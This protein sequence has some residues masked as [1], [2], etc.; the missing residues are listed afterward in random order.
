MKRL[1]E[2][3]NVKRIF[4]T[5]LIISVCIVVIYTFLNWLIIIKL[6]LLSPRETYVDFSIPL[7]VSFIPNFIWLRPPIKRLY[8]ESMRNKSN[9]G[10]AFYLVLANFA[11]AAPLISAQFW[12]KSTTGSLSQLDNIKQIQNKNAVKYYTLKT[13]YIDKNQY[14][15]HSTAELSGK[16]DK[17]FVIRSFFSL[18]ILESK[19]D[20]LN[21]TCFAW[22][23]VQ[24]VK[25][26]ENRLE[27]SE[28]DK[29][30]QEF[31]N[32][33]LNEI[34]QTDFSQLVYL[35]RIGNTYSDQFKESTKNCLKYNSPH[36][37]FFEAVNE[38]FEK[39]SG[40]K[41]A[42]IFGTFGIGAVLW[43]LIIFFSVERSPIVRQ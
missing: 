32:E 12:L 40:N 13:F 14:G 29:L 22:I 27:Q 16:R 37:N 6:Q 31:V 3:E 7:F 35:E 18:P 26:I 23:G 15:I 10:V 1:F 30:F 24:F 39:R 8:P 11:I 28:K 4:V 5:F 34:N 9:A 25:T 41:L 42:W 17:D 36:S 21:T 38:P 43:F 19:E 2:N 33:S 20:T